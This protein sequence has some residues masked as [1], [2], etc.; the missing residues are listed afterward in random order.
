VADGDP[1]DYKVNIYVVNSGFLGIY[2]LELLLW[3][4]SLPKVLARLRS[5][6]LVEKRTCL[7]SFVSMTRW[8]LTR[9]H[10]ADDNSEKDIEIAN[11]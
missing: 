2:C 1:N 10:F 4:T 8:K 11:Y 5:R 9:G 7:A 3:I 6:L